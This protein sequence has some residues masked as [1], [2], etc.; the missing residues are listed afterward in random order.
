MFGWRRVLAPPT[1]SGRRPPVSE[2]NLAGAIQGPGWVSSDGCVL[3]F[4]SDRAGSTNLD[5]YVA[6]RGN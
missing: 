5:L 3:Y 2:L 4:A 1:R 6:Q